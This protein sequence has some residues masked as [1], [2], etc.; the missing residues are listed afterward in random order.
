MPVSASITTFH[1]LVSCAQRSTEELSLRSLSLPS[2]AGHI[3]E[4]FL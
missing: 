3:E 2:S 4:H 1:R